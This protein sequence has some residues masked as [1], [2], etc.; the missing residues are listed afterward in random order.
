MAKTA[1]LVYKLVK[2][3][4]WLGCSKPEVKKGNEKKINKIM[5]KQIVSIVL[6]NRA[7]KMF[8]FF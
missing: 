3:V 5:D 6:E 8:L 7:I 1:V 2:S 4:V